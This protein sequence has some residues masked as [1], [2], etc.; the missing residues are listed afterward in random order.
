MTRIETVPG[1][2]A[3]LGEGVIW[4]PEEQCLYWVDINPGLV[5]RTDP[6]TGA[7]TVWA[8]GQPAGCLAVREKGGLVVALRDG[9]VFLD[10]RT[11]DVTP[12]VDPEP[13][14]PG[15]RFNDGAVDPVGRFW[16]G[17]MDMAPAAERKPVGALYRLDPDL[18]VHRMMDGFTVV[19]GLAFSPDGRTMYVSDTGNDVQTIWALDYDARDGVARNRRVFATTF[20]LAGRPD[21]AAVDDAG[22]YWTAGVGG[23]QLV[24]F[25]PDGAVDRIV[26]FPAQKPSRPAFGGAARD[27]L[28]VTTI[29]EGLSAA[30]LEKYPDSGC[31]FAVDVGTSG[32]AQ[33]RFAG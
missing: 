14:M 28:Y 24:R 23:A 12:I 27:V 29:R 10:T 31:L 4:C 26:D 11:G 2:D 7:D 22:G 21:G 32:P 33:P 17:T 3:E 15:N 16:A 25:T 1:T 19:N 13:D 30:D 9:F 20:D 8:M 6:A 5:H 18:S